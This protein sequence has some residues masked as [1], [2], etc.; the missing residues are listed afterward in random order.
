MHGLV[1]LTTWNLGVPRRICSSY[2]GCVCAA[3]VWPRN[4]LRVEPEK[5]AV[6]DAPRTDMNGACVLVFEFPGGCSRTAREGTF[7]KASLGAAHADRATF[8]EVPHAVTLRFDVEVFLRLCGV[9]ARL[10]A[11]GGQM[12]R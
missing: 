12:A 10:G 5:P 4:V 9:F 1:D 11:L 6:R 7:A 2:E 3:R 8:E